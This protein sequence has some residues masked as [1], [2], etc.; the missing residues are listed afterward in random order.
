[1]PGQNLKIPLQLSQAAEGGQH[2]GHA[3][4]GKIRPSAGPG[5]EGVPA[6]QQLPA[7]EDYAALGVAG[8]MEDLELYPVFPKEIQSPSP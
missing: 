2:L 6:E 3:A 8:G 7:A 4:A 1:M 5:E